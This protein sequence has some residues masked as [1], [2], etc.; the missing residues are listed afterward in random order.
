MDLFWNCKMVHWYSC[1][2]LEVNIRSFWKPRQLS[3]GLLTVSQKTKGIW[4]E[5]STMKNVCVEVRTA[6]KFFIENHREKRCVEVS[7]KFFIE[8]LI[9]WCPTVTSSSFWTGGHGFSVSVRLFLRHQSLTATWWDRFF[10]P[11][12]KCCEIE[13]YVSENKRNRWT[14]DRLFSDFFH[15]V[16]SV[17]YGEKFISL[18][19]LGGGVPVRIMGSWPGNERFQWL[20][21]PEKMP[22]RKS[23]RSC[24]QVVLVGFLCMWP[25]FAF[26]VGLICPLSPQ[27]WKKNQEMR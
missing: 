6:R 12:V 10:I 8:N 24:V 5:K 9:L 16:L 25:Q 11:R 4:E 15:E 13:F 20:R 26:F 7:N 3:R 17:W 19:C 23:P 21:C 27:L 14:L 1:Y 2:Q 18:R 22:C